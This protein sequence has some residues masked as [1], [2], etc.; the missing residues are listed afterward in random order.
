LASAPYALQAETADTATTADSAATAP[1]SGLTGIPSGFADGIDDVGGGNQYENVI[2]IAT[3]G[4]DYDSV[5]DA[6]DSITDSTSGN[7]YLVRVMAG[8]FTE[9]NLVE[10]KPYVHVQGSGPNAT[11]ITSART[12]T[13]PNNSAATVDLLDNGRLSNLTVRNDSAGTFGI[14]LY[15]AET[16]RATVVD[17]VVAEAIGAGGTGH[18]AAYWNDANATIRNSTLFAGGAVGFGTAVNAAFGSVN[19]SAGFP[20]ALIENSILMGGSASN[21]ENCNDPSGTGFGL[22]LSNSSP[23]VRDSYICG[24]HRGVV[25][26]INGH[27]QIQNSSVKASSAGSAFLFEIAATGSISLAN[28]GVSYVGNKF[29]GTGTGLRCVHTYD[30]GTYQPLSDGTTT[31]TACN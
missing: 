20:Q 18:F 15:S 22:Q 27:P 29:T 31:A 25:V 14:A 11:I 16:S 8:V 5:A 30:L 26:Y 12:N 10:V 4:G 7:R 9:T 19:I 23:V 17:G 28:S 2:T 6:L 24:G 1:W 3:S 13:T 21:L